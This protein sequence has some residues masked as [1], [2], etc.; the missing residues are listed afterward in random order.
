[1]N[2]WSLIGSVM[3]FHI[4]LAAVETEIKHARTCRSSRTKCMNR[5]CSYHLQHATNPLPTVGRYGENSTMI[6]KGLNGLPEATSDVS[7]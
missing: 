6:A 7:I 3:R 4:S 2:L 5:T 1:M